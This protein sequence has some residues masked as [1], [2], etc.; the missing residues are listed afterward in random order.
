MAAAEPLARRRRSALPLL[1]LGLYLLLLCFA[2][3]NLESTD[4]GITMH[5]ARAL[6]LRGDSGMR[7]SGAGAEWLAEGAIADYIDKTHS[8]GKLGVDGERYYCWFPIGHV[9]WI[10]PCAA[11]GD[12]LARAFPGAELRYQR[13]VA[14]SNDPAQLGQ[15][16]NYL[17]GQFALTQGLVAMTLPAAFGATSLLL[18]LLLAQAF[19]CSR[20]EALLSALAI[21]FGT[22]FFPLTRETLSDGPGLCF[23]LAALL[24]V[25]RYHRE[26]GSWP[27]LLWGGTAAGCAVLT[28]YQHGLLVPVLMLAVWFAARRRGRSWDLVAMALGG[29][30]FLVLL[31]AVDHARFGNMTDTGYPAFGEWFG[32]PPWIGV[33]KLLI[34]AGKGI[35]WYS[36]LL[37]LG[38]WAMLRRSSPMQL[39][40]LGWTL[41]LIPLLLFGSTQGWQ[42]GQCWGARYV[43]PG[44]TALLAIAL[45]QV[46]PWQRWPRTFQA[47]LLLGLLINLTSV[48]APMRGHNQLAGQAVVAR[49]RQLLEAHAIT[50]QDFRAIKADTA[51]R[52]FFEWRYSPLHSFW[53]YAWLSLTGR[54]GD[55]QLHPKESVADTIEPMFGVTG[56]DNPDG[57]AP[58]RWEDRGFR[59]LW[60]VFWGRLLG[61][62]ASL[63][64]L[65]VAAA[66]WAVLRAARRRLLQD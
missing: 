61:V 48:V 21:A 38:L 64:L 29:L 20:R 27:T 41:F 4:S 40:W 56:Q 8:Y 16:R 46:R 22:Q 2:H 65:P 28:R 17:E 62:P 10:V 51:D 12:G 44:I 63:L 58:I 55:D 42:S 30:P 7:R 18:L 57:E 14:G 26:Q 13:A 53:T 34:A 66:A 39:R 45:P 36:P 25:V 23:L 9:W 60:F 31:L 32:Y 43:T 54:F 24:A 49:G 3:G 33:T 6:W 15:S 47:L 50:E 59:H 37:W 52:Y 11:L 35:L 5:A 19:G 1:W